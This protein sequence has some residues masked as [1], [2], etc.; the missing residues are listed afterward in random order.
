MIRLKTNDKETCRKVCIKYVTM[1]YADWK[2]AGRPG[3][4][5]D[6]LANIFAPVV[7][8]NKNTAKLNK[9]WPRNVKFYVDKQ[10]KKR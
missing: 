9:N 5:I 1:Y 10:L 2:A 6:Y 8:V 4:F 3:N 7:G